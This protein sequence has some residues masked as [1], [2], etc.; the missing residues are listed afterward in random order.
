VFLGDCYAVF[1]AY[2]ENEKD[3]FPR[4]YEIMTAQPKDFFGTFTAMRN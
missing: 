4:N 2:P 3:T 1:L